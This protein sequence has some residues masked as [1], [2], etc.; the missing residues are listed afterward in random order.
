MTCSLLQARL[1]L[2][3]FLNNTDI[4]NVTYSRW[5]GRV[6]KYGFLNDMNRL[7]IGGSVSNEMGWIWKKV[8][9]V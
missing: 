2:N 9:I 7:V 1:E 8:A 4:W 3:F 6:I 5:A